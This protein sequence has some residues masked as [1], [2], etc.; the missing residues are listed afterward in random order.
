MRSTLLAR[1]RGPRRRCSSLV[2][3]LR[4]PH[5]GCKEVAIEDDDRR[6]SSELGPP[7][8]SK[9][10][11]AVI[12]RDL[13]RRSFRPSGDRRAALRDHDSRPD[14]LADWLAS[15]R[16]RA[17]LTALRHRDRRRLDAM[18]R[19]AGRPRR[20]PVEPGVAAYL[21][22]GASHD[23]RR[24]AATSCAFDD[25]RS[26]DPEARGSRTRRSDQGRPEPQV[27]HATCWPITGLT[28]RGY[29]ATTRMLRVAT[30]TSRIADAW[31][32]G[33]RAASPAHLEPH[34]R[35]RYEDIC[36]QGRRSQIRLSTTVARS[37]SRRRVR[38]RRTPT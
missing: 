13:A 23:G 2:R 8:V 28:L 14:A 9:D 10:I 32:R 29:C 3:P 11:A 21:P 30:S 24:R 5:D 26:S 17:E 15:H 18:Q 36:R 16:R 34:L 6:R 35:C 22:L 19:E 27:R 20:S 38:Q 25:R 7:D 37:T 1:D 12:D 4:L 33:S 31:A